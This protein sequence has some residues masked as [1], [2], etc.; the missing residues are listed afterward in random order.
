V[1]TRYDGGN[2]G[3]T[4]WQMQAVMRQGAGSRCYPVSATMT[5]AAAHSRLYHRLRILARSV[6]AGALARPRA[7]ASLVDSVRRVSSLL[8]LAM[9][10]RRAESRPWHD[11]DVSARQDRGCPLVYPMFLVAS[12]G[13]GVLHDA[14]SLFPLS[15]GCD[16][17]AGDRLLIGIATGWVGLPVDRSLYCQGPGS[18][19]WLT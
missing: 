2:P 4:G 18:Q 19:G 6:C 16:A 9:Y 13:A 10:C 14:E 1:S 3:R 8:G 17:K 11:G 15:L 5:T 7:G 12:V